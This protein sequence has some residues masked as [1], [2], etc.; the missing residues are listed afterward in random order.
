MPENGG[1]GRPVS[2]THLDVYKR[3]P[4]H[5]DR[6]PASYFVENQR[7][8]MDMLAEHLREDLPETISL[9]KAAARTQKEM[10]E[11]LFFLAQNRPYALREEANARAL[12]GKRLKLS[13]SRLD[14]YYHCPFQYFC[15][16]MLGPVSYTHLKM[17]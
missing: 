5:I 11:N 7:S 9:A 8:A 14:R 2:Y 4:L 17:R 3:Q 10:V 15:Q 13:P 1:G 16:D 6:L 12:L